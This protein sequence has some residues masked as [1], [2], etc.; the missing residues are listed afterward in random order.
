MHWLVEEAEEQA[1]VMMVA[2][3]VAFQE[4]DQAW[5]QALVQ[6]AF[7]LAWA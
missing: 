5:V 1:A 6:A 3:A 7:P 4:Q 2:V